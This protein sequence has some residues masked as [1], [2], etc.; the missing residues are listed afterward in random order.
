MS[1]KLGDRNYSIAFAITV[2]VLPINQY[3]M[4]SAGFHAPRSRQSTAAP[5]LDRFNFSFPQSSPNE[6]SAASTRAPAGAARAPA[7]L[8]LSSLAASS[9]L[10]PLPM[11]DSIPHQWRQD[12]LTLGSKHPDAHPGLHRDR[13]SRGSASH[14]TPL[15]AHKGRSCIVLGLFLTS[16]LGCRR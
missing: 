12:P 9:A 4:M 10:M 8:G 15:P 11:L 16:T 6:T 5:L 2:Y 1:V 3:H 7:P 14:N 13:R